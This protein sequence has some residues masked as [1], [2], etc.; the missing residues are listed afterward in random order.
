MIGERLRDWSGR[1]VSVV[2]ASAEIQ[3]GELLEVGDDFLVLKAGSIEYVI[4]MHSVVRLNQVHE[5]ERP[6]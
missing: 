5:G 4:T 1:R 2:F 6:E 3:V